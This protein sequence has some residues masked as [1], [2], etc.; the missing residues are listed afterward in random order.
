MLWG[1]HYNGE[2]KALRSEN[3]SHFSI[4]NNMTGFFRLT[5]PVFV[6]ALQYKDLITFWI[7]TFSNR[8]YRDQINFS[9]TAFA[10]VKTFGGFIALYPLSLNI[11]TSLI[12]SKAI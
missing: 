4:Q 9:F 5:L 8:E 11:R 7:S 3:F 12:A 2:E 10:Y 6:S 1:Y